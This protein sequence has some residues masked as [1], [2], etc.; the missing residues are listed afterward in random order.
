MGR[1]FEVTRTVVRLEFA[2]YQ[3]LRNY[4]VPRPYVREV[5]SC[6]HSE[7]TT[8]GQY[9]WKRPRKTTNCF[10]CSKAI[11]PAYSDEEDI[12]AEVSKP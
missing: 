10:Q 12:L 8:L 1:F 6:G 2:G 7:E 3:Y 9:N 11:P 4:T 5:F